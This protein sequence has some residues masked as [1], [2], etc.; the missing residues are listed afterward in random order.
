MKLSL[1][2]R[3]CLATFRVERV[4]PVTGEHSLTYCPNGRSTNIRVYKDKDADYW[5]ALAD[6]VSLPTFFVKEL[7]ALWEPTE[8]KSFKD[9]IKAFKNDFDAKTLPDTRKQVS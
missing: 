7:Y 2:C 3:D 1:T 4:Q 8:H 5:E 6:S 9:F